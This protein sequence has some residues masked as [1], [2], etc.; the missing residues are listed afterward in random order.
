[1]DGK[2]EDGDV[3]ASGIYIVYISAGDFRDKKKVV[4]VNDE[5]LRF[6]QNDSFY[7]IMLILLL[8]PVLC[9]AGWEQLGVC[10]LRIL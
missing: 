10:F 7:F 1:M 8:I 4:V 2:N 3:V 9:N 6:T 5:I